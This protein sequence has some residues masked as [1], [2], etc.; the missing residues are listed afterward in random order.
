MFWPSPLIRI[1]FTELNIFSVY[2]KQKTLK[3]ESF[4]T[5]LNVFTVAII[6]AKLSIADVSESHGYAS[7]NKGIFFGT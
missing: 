1:W 5:M 2:N 6:D 3:I 4:V 7:A